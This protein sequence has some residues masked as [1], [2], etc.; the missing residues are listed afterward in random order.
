MTV[1]PLDF[2]A[3]QKPQQI[4]E[5]L[6]AYMRLF[7]RLP[8]MVM[9]DDTQSFWLVSNKPA[10]S[11]MILRTRKEVSDYLKIV[12]RLLKM[13]HMCALCEYGYF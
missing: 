2:S 12:L 7:A 9:V 4:Q 8:G 6:I 3:T 13:W 1:S 5:N 11:N 10:P